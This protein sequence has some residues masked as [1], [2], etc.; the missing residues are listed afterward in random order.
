MINEL[1]KV[2]SYVALVF[3]GAVVMSL[4][5]VSALLG[6]DSLWEKMKEKKRRQ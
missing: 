6:L 3:G 5:G 2:L 4:I 1:L